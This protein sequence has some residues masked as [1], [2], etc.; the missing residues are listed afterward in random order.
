MSF[1]LGPFST[2]FLVTILLMGYL[3]IIM[4]RSP[5]FFKHTV[6]FSLIG[7]LI[8]LIRM[9]VPLNFPF[10]YSIY[11]Y[12]ILPRMVDFS[13]R[14]LPG[15]NIR[16]DTLMFTIWLV[17]ACI[18]LLQ[19]MIQYIRLQHAVSMLCID[20]RDDNGYMF[21]LFH[22]YCPGKIRIAIFP[23]PIS[24]AVTGLLKPTIILPDIRHFSEQEL[25]Y[26]CQHELAHYK[27]HHLWFGL[28]MEVVCRIHWWNPFVQYLKKEFALFLELSNDFFLIQSNP[29]FNTTEYANLILRTAKEVHT[30][31]YPV[32]SQL[33]NFTITSP[34]VLNTRIR[35]ILSSDDSIQH[36]EHSSSLF[37]HTLISIAVLLS[38]FFVPEASFETID[39]ENRED[40]ISISTDN[41]YIIDHGDG[42]SIYVNEKHFGE[43]DTIPED[44]RN[45]TVYKKEKVPDEN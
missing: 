19:F 6:K 25:K 2:C 29:D 8:I 9:A 3:H 42:Y 44:F 13:T 26:I 21:S 18:L 23:E 45:L 22:E 32:P 5:I 12:Q 11:S 40:G 14:L 15:T 41:A 24:P 34:S 39:P 43:L 37:C 1:S 17:V 33:M 30:T 16:V 35:F 20:E 28:L 31:K 36:L 38:V 4:H 7:I 27:K 10:T